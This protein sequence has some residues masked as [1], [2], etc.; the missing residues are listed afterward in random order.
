MANIIENLLKSDEPSIRYK[1]RVRVLGED[2]DSS[3][4]RRL[5]EEIRASKRI[6]TLLSNR[7]DQGRIQ[8]VHHPYKK[9]TG[10]HWVLATLADIGH[11]G[12][13]EDLIPI[14]DQVLDNW[15]NPESIR[16]IEYEEAP[17]RQ[18]FRGVP[19]L[20]GR[21]R[22]C[23]SQQGNALYSAIALGL[24]DERCDQLAEC[25]MRWQWPDGGWNCDRRPEAQVSSF[26]ETLLP[27]RGLAHYARST[28][29]KQASEAVS[30]AAEVFLI[31]KLFRS[32]SIGE[33]MNPQFIRLHYP[34]Y[35]RYDILAGLKVIA[36]AGLIGDERCRAALDLIESKRL[37]DGGW[38][39]EERFYKVSPETI[40]NGEF[41]SWGGVHKTRMNEWITVDALY[42][43]RDAGRWAPG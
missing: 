21:A 33:V 30:R 11:P 12:G 14:R 20:R 42:V 4:V 25:L 18:R 7:D 2:E 37:P 27:L 3:E 26:W 43:L 38:P 8:P 10:A 5:R 39:A 9:W 32:C 16:E 28:G 24:M 41:V 19:I 6:R 13:D 23:A 36:E 35:W 22:R 40:S 1:T 29:S 34:C 31:R 15:L 17:P